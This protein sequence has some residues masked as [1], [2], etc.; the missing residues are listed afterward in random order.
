M[1][2]KTAFGLAEDEFWQYVRTIGSGEI[3]QPG[4]S[5]PNL[6][7]KWKPIWKQSCRSC[8]GSE[9][10][11]HTPFCVFNCPTGALAYGDI[12]DEGSEAAKMIAK[13]LPREYRRYEIPAWEDTREGVIY[14][15]KGI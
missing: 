3:D 7:M 13:L 11:G 6:Y 10:T 8:E 9:A 4:G 15:E 1:S 2:C 12:E 14:L 5:W